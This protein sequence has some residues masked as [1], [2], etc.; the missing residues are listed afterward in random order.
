MVKTSFPLGIN[1][2]SVQKVAVDFRMMVWVLIVIACT[3]LSNAVIATPKTEANIISTPMVE[4]ASRF[5][6]KVY[7]A[8]GANLGNYRKVYVEPGEVSFS[9]YWKREHRTDVADGYQ[10]TVREKYGALLQEQLK[11][12]YSESEK[13]VVVE[14][15]SEAELIL[16]PALENLNIFGP[17]RSTGITKTFV[18]RAGNATFNLLIIDAGTGDAVAKFVDHRETREAPGRVLERANRATNYRD[19]QQLM[20]RWSRGVVEYVAEE[21]V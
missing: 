8:E 18:Y 4:T 21:K 19:F 15:R 1:S 6:D 13:Y 17:E 10:S 16:K 3:T 7:L 2:G 14:N 20:K 5:F 9:E 12:A 11:K